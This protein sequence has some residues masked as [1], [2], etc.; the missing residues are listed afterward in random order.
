MPEEI[1]P[2]DFPSELHR[3][4]Q[5]VVPIFGDDEWL[6]CR[7]DPAFAQPDGRIDPV[8]IK[9][10]PCP[11]LS[12]NRS[13]LSQPWHVLC[14]LAKFSSYAVF[15]LRHQDV[16]ATVK[17][18]SPSAP[19]HDVKTE[20]DPEEF[21]YSHCETRVYRNGRRMDSHLKPGPK[22][23]LRLIFGK[24]LIREQIDR[25]ILLEVSRRLQQEALKAQD[26]C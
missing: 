15:K 14:P 18:D 8:H 16:P 4:G 13:G 10:I 9:G 7:F 1:N 6:Y 2:A 12:S 20:H 26:G 22:D 11:D 21:N 23:K 24:I 25:A 5:P 19:I 3:R 17:G